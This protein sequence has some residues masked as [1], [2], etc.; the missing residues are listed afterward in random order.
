MYAIRS[1]YEFRTATPE[2]FD[3][4]GIPILAGRAFASTDTQGEAPV[5]ILNQAS[6]NFV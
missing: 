2:Y 1:Y 4:A 5:V 3:A 6:Y